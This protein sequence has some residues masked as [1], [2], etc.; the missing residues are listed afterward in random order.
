MKRF[1]LVLTALL[2]IS[3][4]PFCVAGGFSVVASIK[5]VHALVAGVMQGVA[6]PVLLI[7]GGA[8]PHD[9]SL[10]PS[11]A[12]AIYNAD[13]VFWVGNQL[14]FFLSKMLH[15]TKARNVALAQAPGVDLLG[16]RAGGLWNGGSSRHDHQHDHQQHDS[17][18]DPHIW[19]DPRNAVAMVRAIRAAL[20][21]LDP[22][23]QERYSANAAALIA[24]LQALDAALA[25]RL[26]SIKDK[27]YIVFH[28]GYQYFERRYGLA[29]AGSV[30]LNPDK[31]T[32]ARRISEIR[33]RI[34]ENRI[35]CVFSEPQFEPA[36]VRV[37]VENTAVRTGVLDP[38][39]GTLPAG[40]DAY[41]H[42]LHK[43]AD[44]LHACLAG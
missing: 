28:D 24:R 39:G 4:A 19:L 5:P 22:G 2:G 21:D 15:S 31:K 16:L 42:I 17:D 20:M 32:G 43:L 30:T 6:E 27:P 1:A 44:N 12:R 25:E 9:F 40:P 34:N 10:R 35:V 26:A 7:Q 3:T 18:Y 13:L 29:A 23:R 41:F 37:L 38:V 36:L 14:E 8:S 11:E 33:Q